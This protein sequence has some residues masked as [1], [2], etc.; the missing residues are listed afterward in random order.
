MMHF[1]EY[2]TSGGHRPIRDFIDSLHDDELTNWTTRSEVI[3]QRLPKQKLPPGWVDA[4]EGHEPL[5]EFRFEGRDSPVR[6][7]WAYGKQ[8]G[9]IVLFDGFYKENKTQEQ[10]EYK[11]IYRM[12]QDWVKGHQDDKKKPGEKQA[13]GKR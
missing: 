1:T 9:E 3:L 7:I 10:R 4:I 12:Y 8:K 2:T 11:R 6:I 13:R 5:R